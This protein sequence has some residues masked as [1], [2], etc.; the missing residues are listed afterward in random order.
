MQMSGG[1]RGMPGGSDVTGDPQSTSPATSGSGRPAFSRDAE[2]EVAR[3]CGAERNG[4]DR[5]DMADVSLDEL[6]RKR[7]AAV[8]GR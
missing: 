1:A 7:G 5:G 3:C 8:K 2:P 6:I 4:T